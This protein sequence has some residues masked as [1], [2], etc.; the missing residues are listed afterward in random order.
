MATTYT[1]DPTRSFDE[2]CDIVRA[3][4]ITHKMTYE[5]RLAAQRA[6]YGL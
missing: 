2:R 5:E 4:P 1:F 3:T 6:R